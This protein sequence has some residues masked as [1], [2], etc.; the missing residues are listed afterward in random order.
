ME[1]D[2]GHTSFTDLI[3]IWVGTI[4]GHLTL[5]DAVLW[6]TLVFTLFRIYIIMRDEI[7]GKKP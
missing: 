7:F 5:S 4:L 6:A 3:V 2:T 1:Q